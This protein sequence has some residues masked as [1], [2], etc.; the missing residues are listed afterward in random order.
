MTLPE[1]TISL[2]FWCETGCC[3]LVSLILFYHG[4]I[5]ER[6]IADLTSVQTYTFKTL[7]EVDMDYVRLN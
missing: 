2:F 7:T 6:Y 5:T 3:L 1:Q 4:E